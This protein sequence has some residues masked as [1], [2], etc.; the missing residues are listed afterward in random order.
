MP[1]IF[2]LMTT[3]RTICQ[4]K[5]VRMKRVKAVDRTNGYSMQQAGFH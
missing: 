3:K 4:G 5:K 1:I 2:T